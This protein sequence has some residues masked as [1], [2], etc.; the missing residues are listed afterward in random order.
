MSADF[1]NRILI[2]YFMFRI[3]NFRQKHKNKHYLYYGVYNV[4]DIHLGEPNCNLLIQVISKIV[5]NDLGSRISCN[6]HTFGLQY[7]TTTSNSSGSKITKKIYIQHY[8][9]EIF[10]KINTI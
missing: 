9:T 4:R 1:Y 3:K 2:I 10:F 6:H 7:L 5:L 8:N